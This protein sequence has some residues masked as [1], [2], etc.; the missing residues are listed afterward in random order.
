MVDPRNGSECGTESEGGKKE[1]KD[2][3]TTSTSERV[4]FEVT[5]GGITETEGDTD[6]GVSRCGQESRPRRRWEQKVEG[7]I[8]GDRESYVCFVL[9]LATIQP[10]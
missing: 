5:T 1:S 8:N 9:H 3:M 4:D 10:K 6:D 7:I 2:R